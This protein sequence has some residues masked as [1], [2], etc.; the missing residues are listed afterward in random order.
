MYVALGERD[1]ANEAIVRVLQLRPGDATAPT[2]N[3][4]LLPPAPPK[5]LPAAER[6]QTPEK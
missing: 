4:A 2:L 5:E 1:K 3:E 6:V